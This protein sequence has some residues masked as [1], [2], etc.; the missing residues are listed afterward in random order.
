MM[1]FERWLFLVLS[2]FSFDRL[3]IS[4]EIFSGLKMHQLTFRLARVW[5]VSS[6]CESHLAL[7][8]CSASLFLS[9]FPS[10]ASQLV[11]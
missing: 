3:K 2:L 11:C 5:L 8:L 4:V 10:L 1:Y 6:F 7:F 9:T